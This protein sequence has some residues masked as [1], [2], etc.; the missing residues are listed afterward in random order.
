MHSIED[1][2]QKNSSNLIFKIFRDLKIRACKID[3]WGVWE[4]ER[5]V[6]GSRNRLLGDSHAD[7]IFFFPS[8]A[9]YEG[10]GAFFHS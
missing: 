3:C 9:K 8:L 1:L 6:G 7:R 4:K 10:L 5:N 2:L